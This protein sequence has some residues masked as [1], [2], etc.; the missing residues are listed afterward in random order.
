MACLVFPLHSQMFQGPCQLTSSSPPYLTVNERAADAARQLKRRFRK[1]LGQPASPEVALLAGLL[2]SLRYEVEQVLGHN[3]ESFIVTFPRIAGLCEEDVTDAIGYIG[4]RPLQLPP[5]QSS[6]YIHQPYELEASYMGSGL[7]LCSHYTE[8]KLCN[9]EADKLPVDNVLSIHYS[10]H[11]LSV[12]T[13]SISRIGNTQELYAFSPYREPRQTSWS[14]PIDFMLGADSLPSSTGSQNAYWYRVRKAIQRDPYASRNQLRRNITY[15]LLQGESAL[16]TKFLQVLQ[17]AL[18][19]IA[20]DEAGTNMYDPIYV[21]AKGAAVMAMRIQ[22]TLRS[23]RE[24]S[25]EGKQGL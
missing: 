10:R 7:G 2:Q 17:E 12:E 16:N 9:E 19:E 24:G 6:N 5:L 22:E 4:L 15:V 25:S 20:G 11:A 3:L 13:K 14:S 1:Y 23:G 21:A 8:P 18:Q